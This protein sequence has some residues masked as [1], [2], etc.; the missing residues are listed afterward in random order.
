MYAELRTHAEGVAE[1]I[2]I[3]NFSY[4]FFSLNGKNEWHRF[5]PFS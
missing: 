1:G 3:G 4:S 2:D 5:R